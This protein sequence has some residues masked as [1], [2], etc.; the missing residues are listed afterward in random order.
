[1]YSAWV[2]VEGIDFVGYGSTAEKSIGFLLGTLLAHEVEC[3]LPDGWARTQLAPM[4]TS[5]CWPGVEGGYRNG[6]RLA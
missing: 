6:L 3:R 4:W 5:W 2:D 1:M